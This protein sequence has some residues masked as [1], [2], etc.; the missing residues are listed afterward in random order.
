MFE[1]HS[2][3]KHFQNNNVLMGQQEFER[4]FIV[5]KSLYT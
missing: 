2:E 1:K 3:N 4:I 5:I